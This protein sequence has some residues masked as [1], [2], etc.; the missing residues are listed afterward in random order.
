MVTHEAAGMGPAN[1]DLDAAVGCIESDVPGEPSEGPR[2]PSPPSRRQNQQ[3]DDTARRV[4]SLCAH[5]DTEGRNLD[6]I[7]RQDR[8]L[9]NLFNAGQRTWSERN[10]GGIA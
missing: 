5:R 7:L 2:Q 1:Y 6:S 10:A 9:R 4:S 3:A 8:E